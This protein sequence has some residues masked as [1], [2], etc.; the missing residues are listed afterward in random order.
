MYRF[1]IRGRNCGK[2]VDDCLSS[3]HDQIITDWC[4]VVIVDPC[5]DNT[6][7]KLAWWAITDPRIKVIINPSPEG[8]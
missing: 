2:Y 5:K 8:V 6:L 4:A 7:E 1:I 3:L